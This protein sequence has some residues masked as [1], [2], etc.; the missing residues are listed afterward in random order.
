M[1]VNDV[2]LMVSLVHLANMEQLSFRAFYHHIRVSTFSSI[3]ILHSYMY[4][5]HIMLS[6]EPNICDKF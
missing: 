2:A 5:Y 3:D 1:I 6:L 4:M